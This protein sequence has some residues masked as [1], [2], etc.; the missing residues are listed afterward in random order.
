MPE[1]GA[2]DHGTWSSLA[3]GDEADQ[4]SALVEEIYSEHSFNNITSGPPLLD[5]AANDLEDGASTTALAKKTKEDRPRGKE[6][7]ILRQEHERLALKSKRTYKKRQP[8]DGGLSA[9]AAANSLDFVDHSILT[10]YQNMILRQLYVH[11]VGTNITMRRL[12]QQRQQL[13]KSGKKKH[14]CDF[15][16]KRYTKRWSLKEHLLK[17]HPEE[18]RSQ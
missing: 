14:K 4:L 7:S 17:V 3:K 16:E 15:C 8:R 11:M 1:G 2:L 5:I 12:V 13:E 6:M 10:E 18:T 9:A